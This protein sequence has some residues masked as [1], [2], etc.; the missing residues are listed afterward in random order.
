MIR[1]CSLA[2]L[3]C[4]VAAHTIVQAYGCRSLGSIK[5]QTSRSRVSTGRQARSARFDRPVVGCPSGVEDLDDWLVVFNLE[6]GLL[7]LGGTSDADTLGDPRL[8]VPEL[9]ETVDDAAWLG[10]GLLYCCPRPQSRLGRR[11]MEGN[12]VDLH[13]P[14]AHDRVPLAFRAA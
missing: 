7:C 3:D 12:V 11:E 2:L 9:S 6:E 13:V 4:H 5:R 1:L 8:A 10:F 14:V